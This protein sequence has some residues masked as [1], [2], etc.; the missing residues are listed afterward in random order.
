M[1]LLSAF[2]FVSGTV[3]DIAI[4]FG[5]VLIFLSGFASDIAFAF[6]SGFYR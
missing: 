3:F 1:A 6:L 5:F 2:G 4:K